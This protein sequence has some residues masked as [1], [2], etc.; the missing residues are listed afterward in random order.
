MTNFIHP[1]V[2]HAALSAE[3]FSEAYAK[4]F[5]LTVRFLL[6]KGAPPDVAEEV[7]QSA[8]ARGWE[9]RAQL[10]LKEKLIPWINRIAYHR[11]CNDR[12]RVNRHSGL[13]ETVVAAP[14]QNTQ[15]RLDAG[16]VLE[17][18]K[19]RDQK[20]LAQRYLAGME[21]KEIAAAQGI[22]EIAVRVRLHR[23]QCGIRTAI[24][25]CPCEE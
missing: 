8:W 19:P 3:A 20:L 15:E 5:H 10:L 2:P 11:F 14:R 4:G 24:L 16:K 21:M 25:G 12:K 18:C 23:C 17:M 9:A 13:E 1:V 22:S 6:S 7:S